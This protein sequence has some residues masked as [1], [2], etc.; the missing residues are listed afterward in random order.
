M[1]N[2]PIRVFKNNEKIGVGYPR[3]PMQLL[4]TIWGGDDWATD[5]G[6]TKTNWSFAPFKAYFE[7]F[8][9]VGCPIIKLNTNNCNSQ[10]YWWNQKI[11]WRL[12]ITQKKLYEKYRV[13]YK[14]YD[15]CDD[16]IRYPT[17]PLECVS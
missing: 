11:Y 4:A 13:N 16:R 1:E 15:Y 17:P 10:S 5:G 8:N 12:S 9:I 14:T 6:L 2:I 7:D 3:Q